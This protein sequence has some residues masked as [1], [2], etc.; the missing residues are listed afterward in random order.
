MSMPHLPGARRRLLVGSVV[1]AAAVPVLGPVGAQAASGPLLPGRDTILV[2][3]QAY[4]GVHNDAL[5]SGADPGAPAVSRRSVAAMAAT[6][7]VAGRIAADVVVLTDRREFLAARGERYS[8]A[9][10]SVRVVSVRAEGEG[11]VA[12]VEERTRLYYLRLSSDQPEY[13]E[14][15]TPRELSFAPAAAGGW[16]LTGARLVGGSGPTPVNEVAASS[17]GAAPALP[18]RATSAPTRPGRAV[19]PRSSTGAGVGAKVVTAAYDYSAMIA[20]ER[21]WATSYNPAYRHNS[22]DDCTNFLSQALRAGGWAMKT[23]WYRNSDVWWYNSLNQSWTWINADLWYDFAIGQGRTHSL[24]YV[25]DL[26]ESDVLQADWQRD[27]T[28]DHS[29]MVTKRSNG[30][31]YLTYHTN[32][33]L[34]R[35]FS[36]IYASSPNAWWYAHRT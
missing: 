29:M 5:L 17:S 19:G 10:S 32:N 12:G 4:V 16:A 13:T 22:N 23:G 25:Y 3:A 24:P 9:V 7:S 36:S 20:Y 2:A 35:S 14:F 31:I 6:P 18:S 28:I 30:E 8:R 26:V 34:E 33:T 1:L 11:A 21:K 15:V 27:G